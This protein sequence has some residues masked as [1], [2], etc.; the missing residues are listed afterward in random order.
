MYPLNKN[1]I[2]HITSVGGPYIKEGVLYAILFTCTN[3]KDA[4]SKL[5]IKETDWERTVSKY[6]GHVLFTKY[7]KEVLIT[8]WEFNQRFPV[9]KEQNYLFPLEV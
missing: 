1:W 5:M 4:Y 9:E 8:L 2:N 7:Y 6:L 3:G